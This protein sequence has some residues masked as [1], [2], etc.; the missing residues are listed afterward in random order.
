MNIFGIIILVTLVIDFIL[1]LLADYYNLQSLKKGLPN[2]FDDVYDEE[3]YNQSQRY[4][5]VRTKFGIL[6]SAFNLVVL[7]IFWFAGGFNWLDEVVRNWELGVIWTGLAYIGILILGRSI[8]SLPFSIYSTFVIE[9]QFG[10]NKTTPK[11]FVLDLVK[12][13]GNPARRSAISWN[14]GLFHFYSML[15]CMPGET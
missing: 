3:T 7:L 11:T 4:T 9:E 12:G 6:T 13:F 5:Q 1:N 8:L 15:G 2:E 14:I 10:F